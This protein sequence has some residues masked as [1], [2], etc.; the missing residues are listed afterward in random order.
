MTFSNGEII[1]LQNI[2]FHDLFTADR[3]GNVNE[4]VIFE[5][6]RYSPM[7]LFPNLVPNAWLPKGFTN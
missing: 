1:T 5:K 2:P 4:A 6:G 3:E 7:D